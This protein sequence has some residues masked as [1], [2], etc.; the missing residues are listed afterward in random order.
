MRTRTQAQVR[1]SKTYCRLSCLALPC[2]AFP[3]LPF[4]FPILYIARCLGYK[5]KSWRKDYLE[6]RISCFSNQLLDVPD[7]IFSQ[8]CTSAFFSIAGG[9]DLTSLLRS[10]DK[11]WKR[12]CD[13]L[14]LGS[15]C[16]LPHPEKAVC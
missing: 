9:H 1:S 7:Q 15:T 13:R 5:P 8:L 4:P 14:I 6:I 16:H 2:L 12:L 3:S 10:F 11:L